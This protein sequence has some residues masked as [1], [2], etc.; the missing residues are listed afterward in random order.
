[1]KKTL[2]TVDWDYFVPEEFTWDIGHRES[3]IFLDMLW[4]TRGR[5]IDEMKTSG[6]Q[7]GFWSRV[8]DSLN[9]ETNEIIVT[10]SHVHVIDEA[11]KCNHVIIIDAHHDCWPLDAADPIKLHCGNWLTGWAAYDRDVLEGLGLKDGEKLVGF[12]HIGR[13]SRPAED[14][15]R[16]A[17]ADLVTR[18]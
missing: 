12:V 8:K 3:I 1:M 5:L 11:A 18:F 14:R 6:E 13:A 9:I 7:V 17:V 16:P 4:H 2:L 15:P 10:D